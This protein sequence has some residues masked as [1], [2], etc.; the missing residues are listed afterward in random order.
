VAYSAKLPIFL[1]HLSEA[2]NFPMVLTFSDMGALNLK[3]MEFDRNRFHSQDR[4]IYSF[5][6]P[7]RGSKNTDTY[8]HIY[9][10]TY[11]YTKY[12]HTQIIYMHIRLST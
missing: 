5:I 8:I 7:N 3:V 12:V 9:T 10:H 6:S 1:A 4:T 2:Q 11:K